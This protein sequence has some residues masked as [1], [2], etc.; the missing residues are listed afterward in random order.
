MAT[1]DEYGGS[2]V[3]GTDRPS[4]AFVARATVVVIAVVAVA[5][6]SWVVRG[7]IVTVT[8]GFLLAAGLDPLVR[9]VQ[10]R[11]GRRG[12]A[13]L[14]VVVALVAALALFVT[15]ALRPAIAQ[16]AEFV[17]DLPELLGRLSARFGDSAV[18][19]Y[20][21]SP[22]VERQVSGAIDDV[23]AFAADSLGAVVGIL[24]SVGGAIFTGFTVAATTVYTM[25]ALPRIRAFAGRAAGDPERV[26][27]VA[28]I[29]RRVGGYVT[30]QL[31]ICASAGIT[32][33]V[34][35]LIIGLPYAALLAMVVAVL[36]AV[37]QVG[38]T[39]AAVVAVLVALTVSFGTAVAVALFFIIYQQFENFVIAP[40]VF[41]SAVSL[42]P[43]AVYLAVLVGGTLAGFVGAILALPVAATVTVVFRYVFR[44]SL[45]AMDSR[46]VPESPDADA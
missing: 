31:G 1:S 11:V 45:A 26:H 25:L 32:S 2:P 13:V 34:F 46:A 40:R 41:A 3:I 18:A 22:E 6:A 43:M 35:F 20:L 30:G 16:A 38:A 5:V 12:V 23:V 24:A 29:F 21:A 44:H 14:T 36:D 17:A 28:E 4:I 42:T 10:R 33:A 8:V 37:P 39:L 19:G 7:V 27:M 9:A 15:V